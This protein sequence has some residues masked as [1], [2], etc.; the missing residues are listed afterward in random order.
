MRK[1]F[2]ALL[3]T[4]SFLVTT[5]STV[6][7]TE[8]LNE[9]NKSN[10]L[11]SVATT[12]NEDEK[13]VNIIV[14]LKETS[15]QDFEILKTPQGK[16]K[17][18]EETKNIR[19]SFKNK[20]DSLGLSYEIIFE[21]DFLFAG[22]AL[23]TKSKNI[24]SIEKIEGVD[25]VEVSI[26]YAKP[27]YEKKTG[28]LRDGSPINSDNPFRSIDSNELI[29]LTTEMQKKY[30]GQG[31]VVSVLD[32]GID[33]NHPILRVSDVSKGKFP[34]KASMEKRM[35]E[36]GINYGSWRTDKVVYAHNYHS[37]GTDVLEAE[38]N[39]HGMH[40]SGTSVGNPN[41]PENFVDPNGFK[42]PELI[43]GTAPEA[44][45]I[46]MNVF[47]GKGSTY[48]H[49]YAKAVE[50]SVKL[51][52]DSINLSLGAPNG[53]EYS[54]GRSME[55]AIEF[56]RNMGS[57]VAIAAGN[58]G[59]HGYSN[60]KPLANNPDYGTVGSPGL[61]KDALTVAAMY[62]TV[63]RVNVVKVDG[64]DAIKVGDVTLGKGQ[65]K[66]FLNGEDQ[67]QYDYVVVP[68]FGSTDEDYTNIDVNGK[69]ALIKRGAITFAQ[70]IKRAADKGA[71]GVII[72]NHETGG[73]VIF[74]MDYGNESSIVNIP[75]VFM[76]YNDGTKL[77]D[78]HNKKVTFFR[79][80]AVIPYAKGGKLTDFSSYGYSTDGI[81]KPDI[82]A[83]GGLIF[84][85]INQDKYAS[86]SGT[87]MATPHVAGA[88]P[89][90]RKA[91]QERH[92][93]SG[94]E[95]YDTIK[96]IMMSTADPILD[97][98]S[99]TN[100]VSPRKQGAGALNMLK[101]ISSDLY[102]VKADGEPKAS[103]NNIES[104][105]SFDLKVVN[106]GN[107]DRQLKYNTVLGTDNVENGLVT[108]TT[109]TLEKIEGNEITVPAKGSRI[110][111]VNIDA[112]KY[113]E[114]LSN[115]MPNG[116]F[117]EGFVFFND[118]ADGT[119]IISIPFSGFRGNWGQVPIWEK[120]IYDFT[121]T[122][123][124]TPMYYE[125]VRGN[126]N[127]GA[128]SH[129]T[130]VYTYENN[131]Y[132]YGKRWG[133]NG[134]FNL[135]GSNG[136]IP[137]GFNI[138]DKL[139][140]KDKIAFSPNG[141]G[142]KDLVGFKGVFYRNAQYLHS[143]VYKEGEQDPVFKSDGSYIVKN[144]SPYKGED[145][146]S[147]MVTSTEFFG[148]DQ[149]GSDLPEGKYKYVVVA[150]S[151]VPGSDEQK[152]EFDL[153]L[154][155]TAPV[156]EK[157]AVQNN[158][159][160]PKITDNLSGVE[161]TILK[162]FYNGQAYWINPSADGSFDLAEAYKWGA[163]NSTIYVY[164][165]DYAGNI[166]QL[167]LDGTEVVEPNVQDLKSG[168]TPV[169][170]ITDFKDKDGNLIQGA[171]NVNMFVREGLQNKVEIVNKADNSVVNA[172]FVDGK[173]LLPVGNYS[174][175]LKE[176]PTFYNEVNP[177]TIEFSVED[178]SFKE[179]VF[180]TTVK[181]VSSEA[182]KGDVSVDLSYNGF[183]NGFIDHVSYIIKDKQGNLVDKDKLKHMERV[184][185]YPIMENGQ[186]KT[187]GFKRVPFFRMDEGEYTLEV[188]T[189]SD[190]IKI[191]K[192]KIDFKVEEGKMTY[193]IIES[194][195]NDT[196]SFD[197][198][199][200]GLDKLPE[201]IKVKLTEVG[202]KDN[203]FNLKKSAFKEFVF[204]GGV[205]N[206]KFTVEI[207]VPE[208]YEVDENN[209][210]VEIKDK[211]IR[212]V[213]IREKTK[214]VVPEKPNDNSTT[215][216]GTEDK[217][218]WVKVGE[219]WKY[220]KE[221]KKEAKSEWLKDEGKWYKFDE[222]GKMEKGKWIKEEGK[223]Y[224]LKANGSMSSKEWVYENGQ[225]FYANESGRI[226]ENEWIEVS[227]KWYYAKAG[228]YIVTNQWHEIGGKWYHFGKDGAL[229]VNT[230]VDGYRVD[231]NGE[232]IK[233]SIFNIF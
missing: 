230:T 52:A 120:P 225:W 39:S 157:P 229:S 94:V 11:S 123:N 15:K 212:E 204:S 72:Y 128:T 206:G 84:S 144:S 137:S 24:K 57:I 191:E 115:D 41:K 12:K 81:F 158:K 9:N 121:F 169:L 117:L 49:A 196:Q 54:V 132:V 122:G 46:F 213:K 165:F 174:I 224:Y 151:T 148:K 93:L 67:K 90:I 218:G 91:L 179:V 175:T 162:W 214:I 210:E 34:D 149:H 152:L 102:V 76:G 32:T 77:L 68:N 134:E 62:T 1:K 17:R 180:S 211:L 124:D 156:I 159:Y 221:D 18:Y 177:K 101:A 55:R 78:A 202:N 19:E 160:I 216:T 184:V 207:T 47:N 227:G 50:D 146:K 92:N 155:K 2:L 16:S 189:M 232:W 30:N 138:S 10:S 107:Q 64:I 20:L 114:A 5:V 105:F 109:K 176:V 36:A 74:V 203:I 4:F 21:Y 187:I 88:V 108:L 31:M 171:E 145:R 226:A 80:K 85:S 181:P 106:L 71:V 163:T 79:D 111:T 27:Q 185:V 217:K 129:M 143:K 194:T 6:K 103:L 154:D 58:D 66:D 98:G 75:A 205:V 228:G 172:K 13:E 167:M 116:Y 153:L 61:A 97:E 135:Y 208:G 166:S 164:T 118:S 59:H 140:H 119:S 73:D 65:T 193:V 141:D 25:S 197:L 125:V 104:K 190:D 178:N 186:F 220:I 37:N 150:N 192:K 223:W 233:R 182:K 200:V 131:P 7:A 130:A 127:S 142:N 29:K 198:K 136:E 168:I 35:K 8:N 100:Y 22:Y 161:S 126:K 56:A 133:Q 201:G 53:T 43:T 70:K 195:D 51:G 82:T 112:T 48:T 3:L 110:V 87:S 99:T 183:T 26:E 96:A 170:K 60:Y 231:K 38:L 147:T 14:S 28:D 33:V 209:F 83:P 219:D 23:K 69:I 89:I 222:N 40:V 173:F 139:Y 188:T 45:L 63:D 113:H 199:F 95:E 42:K 86:M 44:Q 215:E